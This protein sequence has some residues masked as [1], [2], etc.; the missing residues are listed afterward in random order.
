MSKVEIQGL[1]PIPL[2]RVSDAVPDALVATLIKRTRSAATE[3]NSS[4]ARLHHS[5][6]SLADADDTYRDVQ[7]C[8]GPHLV[9]FGALLFGEPLSW[10]IKEMWTNRLETGGNQTV[11]SHANSFISGVIYLT[12]T[13]ASARTVFRRDMGSREFVFSNA[14][15][16]A[17]MGP[18]NA[19]DWVSPPAKPG[20]LVL[21]PSYLLH[22]VPTNHGG[23]RMTLAFNAIPH[24]LDSWGY[25]VQFGVPGQTGQ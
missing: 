14:N 2:M 17:R 1:F 9:E 21:F 23:E 11:H 25:A 20:D 12:E 24:R 13:H 22:E 16:N 5:E 19:T 4:S 8:V 15:R 7:R 18:F 10:R 3:R 6:M